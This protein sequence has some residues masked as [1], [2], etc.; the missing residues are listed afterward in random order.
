[1]NESQVRFISTGRSLKMILA[2]LIET[3]SPKSRSCK[4]LYIFSKY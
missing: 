3:A 2:S 4:T 1:M